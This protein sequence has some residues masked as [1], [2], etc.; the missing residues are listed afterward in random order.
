MTYCKLFRL[1]HSTSNTR[2]STQLS[3]T[4]FLASSLFNTSLSYSYYLTRSTAYLSRDNFILF[5]KQINKSLPWLFY[6][7]HRQCYNTLSIQTHRYKNPDK[8]CRWR[9]LSTHQKLFQVQLRLSVLFPR[10]KSY[11]EIS[12]QHTSSFCK[13]FSVL[14][15]RYVCINI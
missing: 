6:Y 8:P 13:T 3:W 11:P 5:T 9:F 7:G 10:H 14:I 15:R 1:Q 2:P 12:L 4:N